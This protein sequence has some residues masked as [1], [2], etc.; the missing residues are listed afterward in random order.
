M[1]NVRFKINTNL[2]SKTVPD[3]RHYKIYRALRLYTLLYFWSKTEQLQS[4]KLK[5]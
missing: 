4:P 2:Q 1:Y 5:T 3:E